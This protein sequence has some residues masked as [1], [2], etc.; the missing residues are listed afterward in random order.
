M[1]GILTSR[2]RSDLTKKE[3]QAMRMKAS[4]VM[5]III[6]AAVVA[7]LSFPTTGTAGSLEPSAAPAPTMKTLDQIPP[8][9]SQKISGAAR[10]ELVLDLSLIH[11]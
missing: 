6:A 7:M 2:R 9:W 11:I 8:T 10:F 3:V 1:S 5:S 4:Y